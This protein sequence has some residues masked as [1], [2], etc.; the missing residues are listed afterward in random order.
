M[1]VFYYH[2]MIPH[3]EYSLKFKRMSNSKNRETGGRELLGVTDRSATPYFLCRIF[4]HP[5]PPLPPASYCDL[6]K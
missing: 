3:F 2:L 6:I 1:L 4:F 5:K